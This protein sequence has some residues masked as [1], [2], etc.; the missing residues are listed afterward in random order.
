[1]KLILSIILLWSSCINWEAFARTQVLLAGG[2]C[3]ETSGG[4]ESDTDN[5]FFG[6]FKK[7]K[8]QY[9]RL[10]VDVTTYFGNQ[11][12]S[13]LKAEKFQQDTFIQALENLSTQD[14]KSGDQVLIHINTHGSF[15]S[16]TEAHGVCVTQYND[17]GKATH[18]SIPITQIL[19]ELEKLKQKFPELHVALVDNSC[20]GGSSVELANNSPI[21]VI[22]STQPSSTAGFGERFNFRFLSQ[23][24]PAMN[25]TDL[26]KAGLT[27]PLI[28]FGFNR[29]VP[30]INSLRP[31]VNNDFALLTEVLRHF[32]DNIDDDDFDS[33][34]R[35]IAMQ[36]LQ[37]G[38]FD[39]WIKT[40]R[41]QGPKTKKFTDALDNYEQQIQDIQKK[42]PLPLLITLF[43]DTMSNLDSNA[44]MP[45][46]CEPGI[47]EHDVTHLHKMKWW[48]RK[49]DID[50]KKFFTSVYE[51]RQQFNDYFQYRLEQLGDSAFVDGPAAKACSEWT[52]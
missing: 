42:W 40:V 51:L 3:D 8:A 32:E 16:G 9:K 34:D 19:A 21:C 46:K 52:F 10:G 23:A 36:E 5:D 41:D 11:G 38:T 1:M 14:W 47:S 29:D 22:S 6:E 48:D 27:S 4:G 17:L 24:R 37:W 44:L 12:S 13:K 50:L 20:Y 31:E 15:A 45:I 7:A 28:S 26:Y 2:G 33:G 25:L 43:L 35:L 49:L 30:L 18:V 39:Q